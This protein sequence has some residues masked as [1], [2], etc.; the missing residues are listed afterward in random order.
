MNNSNSHAPSF[1][2]FISQ[3]TG[4]ICVLLTE[5]RASAAAV[6]H[7]RN[8]AHQRQKCTTLEQRGSTGAAQQLQHVIAFDQRE[9]LRTGE[10][11]GQ[12]QQ[13]ASSNCM[14]GIRA[15]VSPGTCSMLLLTC[16]PLYQYKTKQEAGVILKKMKQVLVINAPCVYSRWESIEHTCRVA[17]K[18]EGAQELSS[19]K[20]E[21][22]P[23]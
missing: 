17:G 23:S 20:R 9:N 3:R 10:I 1:C 5:L 8:S 12:L 14:S 18:E 22:P 7:S 6:H 2:R 21:Q 11:K 19:I 16:I 13:E 15:L 4:N